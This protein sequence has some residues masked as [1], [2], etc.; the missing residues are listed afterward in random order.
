M[1]LCVSFDA[2]ERMVMSRRSQR[3]TAV[4]TVVSDADDDYA[5]EDDALVWL[6]TQQAGNGAAAMHGDLRV[7]KK[8]S[9]L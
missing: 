5:I 4:Y 3:E 1:G 6:P 7:R 8:Q 9:N 2:I